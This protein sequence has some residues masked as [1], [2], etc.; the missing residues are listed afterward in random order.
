[1]AIGW[2]QPIQEAFASHS[3]FDEPLADGISKT[4][5]KGHE[6]AVAKKV[7]WNTANGVIARADAHTRSDR[8]PNLIAPGRLGK[9]SSDIDG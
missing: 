7:R 4:C 1:M 8:K 6:Q 2:K 9:A 5:V 3:E